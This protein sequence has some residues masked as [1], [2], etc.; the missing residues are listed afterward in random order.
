MA[1]NG[2]RFTFEGNERDPP[3]RVQSGQNP[4]IVSAFYSDVLRSP[5]LAH[6]F[7]DV[8]MSGL[9]N[10][11]EVFMA[12]VM[13]DPSGYSEDQVREAHARLEITVDDLDEMLRLLEKSLLKHE[14]D[15]EDTTAVVS[16]YRGLRP[17]VVSN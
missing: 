4:Q 14:V 8:D 10:H 15:P 12:T 11:Q 1:K 5:R 6:F 2:A 9:M 17:Q 7:R 3:R 16:V 13:G